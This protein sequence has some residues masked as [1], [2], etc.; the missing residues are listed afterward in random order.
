MKTTYHVPTTKQDQEQVKATV[1]RLFPGSSPTITQR[2]IGT[3]NINWQDLDSL[4]DL[5]GASVEY[6]PFVTFIIESSD[7]GYNQ[8]QEQFLKRPGIEV[9]NEIDPQELLN[10]LHDLE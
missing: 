7:A 6:G 2:A 8:E 10:D 5:L 1:K 3:L 9:H 4:A